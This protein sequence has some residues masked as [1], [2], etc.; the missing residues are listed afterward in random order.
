MKF[1]LTTIGAAVSSALSFMRPNE[2]GEVTDGS[3]VRVN[4]GDPD[5]AKT[6]AAV[7]LYDEEATSQLLRLLTKMP[8]LDEVLRQAGV[9]RSKLRVLLYDDEIAQACETRLDALLSVPMRLE[10]SEGKAA[11]TLMDIL[12]KVKVDAIAGIFSARLFGYS[13]LEAVYMKREDGAIG[14]NFL[15][16]KPPE[17]FEPRSDG[18]LRYYPDDGSGGGYGIPVDQRYKFFLTRSR[19]SYRQPYGEALLSRLYWPWYFRT[20]GWKFWA[21]FL[22]RFGS[23]LLV[24]KS[25]D[26]KLMVAALLSAQS[27]AVMGVGKEDDVT[28]VGAAAGNNG[29]AFDSYESAVIR[30]IQKVVLGQTMTSG[31]D[32]GS[33]NR[34]LG[35]V[36][37]NVRTDKR[38]SDIVMATQTMQRIVDALCELNGWAKH[39]VVFADDVGLETDRADRDT[40]LYQ[41]GVRFTPAYYQDQYDLNPTDFTLTSEAEAPTSPPGAPGAGS[42][43]KPGAKANAARGAEKPGASAKASQ[44]RSG[45]F[46]QLLTRDRFTKQ[47]QDVEDL[48]DAGLATGAQPLDPEAVRAAVFSATGPEDLEERLF[49]LLGDQL[50]EGEFAEVLEASL[51][52]ADVL[53][54]VHAEGK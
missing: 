13:V 21:K 33:G 12:G 52:A 1:S 27:Q 46:S 49:A 42:A 40:K 24:G 54:Y 4:V 16:E 20:N 2:A 51:F 26:P 19:P 44:G 50:A 15:G 53:G 18:E 34:A 32:G 37:D 36:H 25:S 22:E 38:N 31:T 35:Q 11:E 39:E 28:A 45:L 29:Q 48:G 47:Q 10:P 43:A 5:S 30:R 23:P 3:L 8:D 41:Q 14:F 7:A 17:W 9:T 6:P